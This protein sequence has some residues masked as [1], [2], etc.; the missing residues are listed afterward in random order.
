M[1]K[2]RLDIIRKMISEFH[3]GVEVEDYDN[4]TEAFLEM[5]SGKIGAYVVTIEGDSYF[6][7][8]WS[9]DKYYRMYECV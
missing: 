6:V 5:D 2:D 1:S 7:P 4:C 3:D 8:R 9:D